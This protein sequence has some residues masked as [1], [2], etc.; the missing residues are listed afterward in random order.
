MPRQ[1]HNSNLLA[2]PVGPFPHAVCSG[3]PIYLSGQ[4]GQEPATGK[5][6][7]G[8]LV[9]Q[10]RQIFRNFLTLLSDLELNFDDVVKVNVFLS[11]MDDFAVMNNVYAEHFSAPYPARTTVAVKGL[12]LGA[13]VEM[14]MIARGR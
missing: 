7:E 8:G 1:A 6:V 12:P 14:E 4:V 2:K 3:E 13:L 5:L 9:A 10:T 11:T